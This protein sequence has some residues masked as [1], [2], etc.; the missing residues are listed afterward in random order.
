MICGQ[1]HM[2]V[3]IRILRKIIQTLSKKSKALTEG[4]LNTLINAMGKV[5]FFSLSLLF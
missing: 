5:H 1:Y 2:V 3:I 4:I